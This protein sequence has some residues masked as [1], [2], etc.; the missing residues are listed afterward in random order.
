[1]SF[2]HSQ[3]VQSQKS[4]EEHHRHPRPLRCLVRLDEELLDDQPKQCRRR[5]RKHERQDVAFEYDWQQQPRRTRKGGL[6]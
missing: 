1:M 4:G 3:A 6:N 2:E 5:E